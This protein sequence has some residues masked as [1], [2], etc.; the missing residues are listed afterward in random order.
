MGMIETTLIGVMQEDAKIHESAS[1]YKI[2]ACRVQ[3]SQ[4][5]VIKGERRTFNSWHTVKVFGQQVQRIETDAKKGATILAKGEPRRNTYT[6]RDGTE[7]SNTEIVADV[8]QV[9]IP[10]EGAAAQQEPA[11]LNPFEQTQESPG[12]PF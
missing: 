2:A 7:A 1:G 3:V 12:Y 10:A 4:E 6:K 8:F 11:A 9:L 5:K